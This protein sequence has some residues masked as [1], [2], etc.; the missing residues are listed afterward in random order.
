MKLSKIQ[1]QLQKIGYSDDAS[2]SVYIENAGGLGRMLVGTFRE[3]TDKY[4]VASFQPDGILFMTLGMA[5]HFKDTAHFIKRE[6]IRNIR[7]SSA[8]FINGR[9]L[10]NADKLEIFDNDGGEAVYILY[11]Y[12]MGENFWQQNIENMTRVIDSWPQ[13]ADQQDAAVP[14]PDDDPNLNGGNTQLRNLQ[15][16]LD[17]GVISQADFDA[18]KKQLSH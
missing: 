18:K 2:T 4:Y 11:N 1:A 17:Q 10:S 14:E 3:L 7:I 6:N 9:L 12:M 8:K 13:P 15:A 16:L 5:R